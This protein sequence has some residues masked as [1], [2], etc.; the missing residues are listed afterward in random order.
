[1]IPFVCIL[2]YYQ[3]EVI[4]KMLLGTSGSQENPGNNVEMTQ[5]HSSAA[6]N[7]FDNDLYSKETDEEVANLSSVVIQAYSKKAEQT[8]RTS[9][10]PGL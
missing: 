3:P 7:G 9:V 6:D 10:K 1:M 8:F 4:R 5:F 2:I